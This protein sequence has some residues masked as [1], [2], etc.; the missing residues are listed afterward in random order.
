MKSANWFYSSRGLM[1]SASI[2]CGFLAAAG[3]INGAG[4]VINMPPPK[5]PVAKAQTVAVPATASALSSVPAMIAQP[6]PD[7]GDVAL[8]RYAAARIGPSDVYDTGP[9]YA[10]IRSYSYGFPWVW[11]SPFDGC[12][13]NQFFGFVGCPRPCT[14]V[15]IRSHVLHH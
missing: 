5:K 12:F 9:R 11:G 13:G 2:A 4:V 1:S 10:G 14:N 3:V 8:S 7:V 6:Q 15:V